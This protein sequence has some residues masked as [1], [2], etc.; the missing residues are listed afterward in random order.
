MDG[1]DDGA[2]TAGG[3]SR[4]PEQSPGL[5]LRVGAF[6][7]SSQPCVVPVKLLV[8]L[9]LFAVV[10]VGDAEDGADALVGAIGQNKD[11][12]GESRLDDA[13]GA[14]GGQVVGAAGRFAGEP[15]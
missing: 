3:T 10:V 13:V 5:Q 1:L 14:G 2:D 12:P 8:V 11:L 4:S 6:A 7:R 15:Q 9:G